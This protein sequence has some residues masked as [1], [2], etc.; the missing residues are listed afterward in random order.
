VGIELTRERPFVNLRLLRGRNLS[1]TSVVA[2]GL[3]LALY[4]T[5]FLIPLYLGTVQGYSPLQIGEVLI[6]VGLPQLAIFPLLPLLMKKF[7]LRLL[8]SLGCVIF[9]VSCFMNTVMSYNSAGDQL[10]LANIVRAFG[11]PF[12][13]VPVAALAVSTLPPKDAPSGSAIFN[14]FRNVGGSFGIA[15]LSTLVTRREQF[16]DL[17]IGESVT[18]YSLSTQA[19]VDAIQQSFIA[20]GFDP[21]TALKQ[22]YAAI[23]AVVQRDAFIMAFNDAFLILAIGLLVS[24]IAIWIVK[25]PKSASAPIPAH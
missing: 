3:G 9:A 19:R 6:W 4:G 2:F 13:I 24:A 7:D 22:A 1:L 25:V 17:R 5:V 20:K 16:H 18:A 11:Q 23:K 21:V 14:I 15:I 12:T 8:V 10:M